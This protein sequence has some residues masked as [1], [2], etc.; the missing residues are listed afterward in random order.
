MVIFLQIL[1]NHTTEK[2]PWSLNGSLLI[3]SSIL[4]LVQHKIVVL[5]VYN[6]NIWKSCIGK[7][8]RSPKSAIMKIVQY[9]A[10]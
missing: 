2:L 9:G 10:Y 6:S 3:H 5:M 1:S 8:F 7:I 4:I